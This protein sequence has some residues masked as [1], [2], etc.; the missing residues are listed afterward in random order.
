MKKHLLLILLAMMFIPFTVNAETRNLYNLIEEEGKKGIIAKEYIG[1]HMDSQ[2][3]SSKG[4]YY[5]DSE[6][7]KEKNNVLFSNLCWQMYR[8]T[9]NGG[10]RLIYNGIP[11]KIYN[12]TDTKKTDYNIISG[13]IELLYNS[14]D[15]NWYG[16]PK[17]GTMGSIQFQLKNADDYMLYY[18][19]YVAIYLNDNY[20]KYGNNNQIDLGKIKPEDIIKINYMAY[21]DEGFDFSIKKRES[22]SHYDCINSSNGGGADFLFSKYNES[23]PSLADVGY[24]NNKKYI[25]KRFS[26]ITSNYYYGNDVSYDDSQN[27]Y[28]LINTSSTL[29][30]N[31][32]Y[33]CLNTSPNTGCEKVVFFFSKSQNF[34][35]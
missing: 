18:N 22:F 9:D 33:S 3:D 6:D 13:D 8:T 32:H 10:T 34:W 23:T 21:T 4:I 7:A 20:V 17:V 12:V 24:M 2:S 1:E 35:D 16:K 26:P 15:N 25:S 27:K 14:N 30:N 29:D 11:N 31:H 5:F 28:Y 19:G